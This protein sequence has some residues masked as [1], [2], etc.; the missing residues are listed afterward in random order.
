MCEQTMPLNDP[1]FVFSAFK[2]GIAAG[3]WT[4][5]MF[6]IL[7][8]IYA[9]RDEKQ[10]RTHTARHAGLRELENA[11]NYEEAA[12]ESAKRKYVM[13]ETLAEL[14]QKRYSCTNTIPDPPISDIVSYINKELLYDF[15]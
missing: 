14:D 13:D 3:I 2:W 11:K 12:I 6:L 7:L 10:R 5:A 9:Y 8:C 1:H 4:V 15:R